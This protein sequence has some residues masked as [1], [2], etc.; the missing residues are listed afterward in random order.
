M[1]KLFRILILATFTLFLSVNTSP[2]YGSD[3][4]GGEDYIM[5]D[6]TTLPA[7]FSLDINVST[8]PGYDYQSTPIIDGVCI[9]KISRYET[10]G[11]NAPPSLY[12][13]SYFVDDK[14]S[15]MYENRALPFTMKQN[16]R[17]IID[18]DYH[19]TFVAR[20]EEGRIGKGSATIR[21]RH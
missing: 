6:V 18:G 8:G 11:N 2:A 1:K 15:G 4:S 3:D 20:D 5:G 7:D 17:G 12:D 9:F 10:G 21:V 13:I 16:F 19:L 14:F